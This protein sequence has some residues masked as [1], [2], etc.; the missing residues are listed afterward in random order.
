[1]IFTLNGRLRFAT[2]ARRPSSNCDAPEKF[3]RKLHLSLACLLLLLLPSGPLQ[4]SSIQP[5]DTAGLVAM[6][7]AIFR[8]TVSGITGFRDTNGLIHTR[9]AFRVE[10]AVKGT[11]AT[12]VVLVHRGGTVGTEDEFIGLW[13]RFRNGAEYLVFVNRGPDGRLQATLGTASVFPLLRLPTDAGS[14]GE[15]SESDQLLLETVRKLAS[16]GKLPGMD[17]TD[18]L[19][20]GR[21]P[22][23][24][25]T[26]MLGGVGSR[27]LQ[28]DRGEP[29]PYLIDADSLPTG[30][31][32]TQATNAVAQALSA[33][34]AV[35]SLRFKLEG[36]Q[37]FGQG[38]DAITA[39]DEK[40]RIQLH[41]N[42]NRINT[43]NVLGIGGRLGLSSVLSGI[44]WEIGGN[45]AGNE[46]RKT[47]R[48]YVVLESGATAM[49]TLSTFTEVLC[50]EIGHALSLAH[51]SEVAIT[52][53]VLTNAMMYYQAHADG[54]GAT[55]GTYD[56][57]IIRQ[58]YPTNTPPWTFSRY[59]DVTTASPN[60]NVPG[61]N[62]FEIRG[63]DLQTTN[64]T[65]VMTNVSAIN[66]SFQQNG[67]QVT[68]VPS[69]PWS[70]AERI[71]PSTNS[72]SYYDRFYARISDGTN[73]S[74]WVFCRVVSLS[75]DSFPFP[76]DG[77]PD[78]WMQRYFGDADP[79]AGPLRGAEDDYDG[80]GLTNL[81]EYRTGMDPTNPDSAQRIVRNTS[82]TLEWQA[83]GYEV[84]E[85]LASTNLTTWTRVG[86][87]Q[88]T[89]AI[90]FP[91][92]FTATASGLTAT[93]RAQ[94]FRVL[95]IP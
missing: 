37:S 86:V 25:L 62:Q 43:A 84:Y 24:A 73:A 65:L 32:F 26:G 64:L 7:D 52:D 70:D 2:N 53:P 79:A 95:K 50:H 76:S 28:P 6:A 82:S 38:A 60:P 10:E 3:M 68:Y 75:Y 34:T 9:T 57:P 8:G 51:S 47:T 55:L 66:G 61:I 89:N 31:T 18:Q 90:P 17:V 27:F 36:V 23:A 77:I 45:V 39:N 19:D 35:T 30:I 63:Y 11:F 12:S 94:N 46:F 67:M 29:I 71:D 15:L 14:T 58:I 93:N 72:T 80:D 44:G 20:D 88:P 16:S 69:A 83:Q 81:Q 91:A 85:I 5:V 92:N 48:G 1:M 42:Y 22:S 33:W 13:P 49:R 87:T 21:A 4:A 54:R 78:S 74:P 56:P 41:D 40:L 59:L